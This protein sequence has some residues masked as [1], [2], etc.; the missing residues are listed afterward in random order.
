MLGFAIFITHGSSGQKDTGDL[1]PKAPRSLYDQSADVYCEGD[2]RVETAPPLPG[3]G[4][5]RSGPKDV[6]S[7][8]RVQGLLT[9]SMH[10]TLGGGRWGVRSV[11]D[12][13]M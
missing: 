3:C 13:I 8:F 5:T 1:G 6:L 4:A 7:I 2:K 11:Q 9:V 10:S 12:I